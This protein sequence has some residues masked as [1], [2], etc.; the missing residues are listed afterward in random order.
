MTKPSTETT[1]NRYS[2]A[3]NNWLDWLEAPSSEDVKW[4]E[5]LQKRDKQVG[6][7]LREMH[8][9]EPSNPKPH[10]IELARSEESYW[11]GQARMAP[12]L[13]LT[14]VQAEITRRKSALSTAAAKAVQQ[15]SGEAGTGSSILPVDKTSP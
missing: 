3:D 2:L 6:E 13:E 7:L 12:G 8:Y 5:A 11:T 4:L 14:R 10:L 1:P 15:P 9:L